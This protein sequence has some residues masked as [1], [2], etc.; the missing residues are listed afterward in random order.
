MNIFKT[1]LK[2]FNSRGYTSITLTVFFVSFNIF[3]ILITCITS[4]YSFYAY[5][6]YLNRIFMFTCFTRIECF[7]LS[8]MKVLYGCM[9][10]D[11]T[12]KLMYLPRRSYCT[13][14]YMRCNNTIKAHCIITLE[15]HKV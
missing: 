1:F 4:Y 8:S 15:K 14:Q 2:D 10:V 9:Y 5:V 13:L 12:R 3:Q 7:F 6:I 11:G